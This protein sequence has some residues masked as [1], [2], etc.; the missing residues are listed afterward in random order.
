M[1]AT[2]FD[3]RKFDP[4]FLH[5]FMVMCWYDEPNVSSRK[6]RRNPSFSL[7][8]DQWLVGGVFRTAEERPN[9]RETTWPSAGNSSKKYRP[10]R[11]LDFVDCS[12]RNKKKSLSDY[13]FLM[14]SLESRAKNGNFWMEE[15]TIHAPRRHYIN[16][17]VLYVCLIL[18][19]KKSHW[20]EVDNI[21]AP[22][23]VIIHHHQ[24]H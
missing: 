18:G 7:G 11:E 17:I 5:L 19:Q 13:R 10:F 3:R 1:L 21:T 12:T 14:T 15:Q 9:G 20:S 16:S 2:N 23:H 4:E 24:H 22:L 8:L 6:M